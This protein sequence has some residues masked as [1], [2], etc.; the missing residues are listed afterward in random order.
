MNK[1]YFRSLII[2]VSFFA[3][4]VLVPLVAIGSA[5][6]TADK[7]FYNGVIWTVDSK[8]PNAEAVAIKDS[9]FVAVGATKEV[10]KWR[11]ARTEVINLQG[12][13]VVP[14][15][16]DNHVHFQSAAAF[17]E[18]NIMNVATQEEFARRVKEVTARLAKGEW[19]LGGYWG[20]Y[21]QWS[22]GSAGSG[23]RLAEHRH[24]AP[25]LRARIPARG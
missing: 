18:F 21:D 10:M 22:A 14:G 25:A 12:K 3:V 24:D 8:N 7:I 17:L 2:G 6:Q 11:G 19:I 4:A 20:A 16:N 23:R 15:F 5:Q 9:R 1:T 13:F